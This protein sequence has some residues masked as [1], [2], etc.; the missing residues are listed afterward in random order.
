MTC[1]V[2]QIG[3]TVSL[4]NLL[5]SLLRT[6]EILRHL[7][8]QNLLVSFWG[9]GCQGGMGIGSHELLL[10]MSSRGRLHAKE[11]CVAFTLGSPHW[12]MVLGFRVLF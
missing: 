5:W 4:H 8:P 7:R 11:N 1:W 2:V 12:P 10:F 3:D 9:A 6:E